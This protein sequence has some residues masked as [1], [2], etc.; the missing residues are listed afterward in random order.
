[1][2][3]SSRLLVPELVCRNKKIIES[4][5]EKHSYENK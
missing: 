1:M 2:H 3:K 5:C 4:K